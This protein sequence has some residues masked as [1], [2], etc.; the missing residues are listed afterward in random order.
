MYGFDMILDSKAELEAM[1]YLARQ[2]K[3]KGCNDF[4]HH[5]HGAIA[6]LENCLDEYRKEMSE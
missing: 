2:A 1:E 4:S 3:I 5:I 6:V